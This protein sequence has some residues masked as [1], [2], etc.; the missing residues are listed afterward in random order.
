MD[1]ESWVQVGLDLVDYKKSFRC[2]IFLIWIYDAAPPHSL[3]GKDSH[4][5]FL[6][7]NDVYVV[8][9]H[10]KTTGLNKVLDA[11][12]MFRSLK[13]RVRVKSVLERKLEESYCTISGGVFHQQWSKL[14]RD[15]RFSGLGPFK[16]VG[17]SFSQY[18]R[19]THGDGHMELELLSRRLK[20]LYRETLKVP[21]TELPVTILARKNPVATPVYKLLCKKKYLRKAQS[22]VSSVPMVVPIGESSLSYPENTRKGPPARKVSTTGERQE[23]VRQQRIMRPI[24]GTFTSAARRVR[25]I[26]IENE[27]KK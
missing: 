9:L 18:E 8:K 12:G 1:G 2:R 20:A 19:R 25:D 10:G 21:D 23:G 5:E 7:Q 24:V 26:D 14:S 11:E 16:R 3:A 27:P 22:K 4:F 15:P 6:K 13:A 17:F